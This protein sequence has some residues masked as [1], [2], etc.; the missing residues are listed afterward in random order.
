MIDKQDKQ[1]FFTKSNGAW[2]FFKKIAPRI[3]LKTDSAEGTEV[4]IKELN[5]YQMQIQ[6]EEFL[7]LSSREK[8]ETGGY[9]TK[10]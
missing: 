6:V 7:Q 10:K 3:R 4:N 2:A 9:A 8:S 1:N 5:K